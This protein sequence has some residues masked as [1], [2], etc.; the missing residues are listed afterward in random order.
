[1]K[2]EPNAM[3]PVYLSSLILRLSS[4][5]LN[6]H[7]R[8]HAGIQN[9]YA[10]LLAVLHFGP[11]L[12]ETAFHDRL[13]VHDLAGEGLTPEPGASPRFQLAIP[14]L[15]GAEIRGLERAVD[16]QASMQTNRITGSPIWTIDR[17]A[18]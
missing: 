15:R 4:F 14:D 11:H 17:R 1:M 5:Q 2:D 9:P 16:A 3:F 13:D 7:L 12:K 10:I 8:V 6:C 18:A